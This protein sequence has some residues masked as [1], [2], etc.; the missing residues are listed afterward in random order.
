MTSSSGSSPLRTAPTA[1][2]RRCAP[3][4]WSGCLW[5]R[6][7]G[8]SATRPARYATCARA[9]ARPP[10]CRSSCRT[11]AA[12]A[13]RRRARTATSAS[14]SCAPART[15]PPR[16]SPTG[17]PRASASRSAP[18]PLLGC[19]AAR[20]CPSCGGVPPNSVPPASRWHR[21][22]GASSTSRR[23][24]CAPTSAGCFCSRPTWPGSTS[25]GCSRATACPAATPSPPDAQCA[26]CSP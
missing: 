18:R 25:M 8:A 16:R 4:M 14:W 7:P 9:S 10:R 15:C 1:S 17:S 26:R 11:G 5:T 21:P 3:T 20:G 19:C 2:T 22:T 23:G 13:H 24:G 12:S 6:P